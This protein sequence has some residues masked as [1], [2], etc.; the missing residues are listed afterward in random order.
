M[1]CN[2]T[3]N[4][5]WK[6]LTMMNQFVSQWSRSFSIICSGLLR[7]H[8]SDPTLFICF[9]FLAHAILFIWRPHKVRQFESLFI[10][11]APKVPQFESLFIWRPPKVPQFESPYTRKRKPIVR[12]LRLKENAI[13]DITDRWG[14][15]HVDVRSLECDELWFPTLPRLVL[16]EDSLAH[17]PHVQHVFRG[18]ETR[19]VE[20]HLQ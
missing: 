9:I 15:E 14:V 17:P 12:I 19:V 8:I 1:Q 4:C 5:H 10:W 6:Y 13:C 20:L 7:S 18:R 11:R 16:I 2:A 3:I